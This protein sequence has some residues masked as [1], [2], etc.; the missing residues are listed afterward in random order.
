MGRPVM[1]GNGSLT[2]GLN[3]QGLVHDFYYP[4][5][6][7]DNLNTS[8]SMHHR[9]GVWVDGAFSW[10]DDG[11]WIID[12]DFE[13]TALVSSIRM[14]S[15]SLGIQ[16]D[17]V[18]FVDSELNAFCR[19]I[20]VNN[21][22]AEYRD[23]RLFMHQVFQ[24][25]RAGRAD[26][27]LFVPEDNYILDYK[28]RC[29]L[30]IYGQNVD[31]SL[32]D[33]FSVGNYGIEG[34][35]GTY[36]DAE[37]GEL[38]GNSVEHGGVDSV[39][40]FLCSLDS[41]GSQ[42]FDY[43]VVAADSQFTAE[44][45]HYKVKH[46]GLDHR[47]ELTREYW[48]NWLKTANATELGLENKYSEAI[49]KSLMVIK[50]HMD[51]RGG[52]IASCDSSIYNYGRD[53]YSYV[54]P[55]DGAYAI[56]PLI[57]LGY[58]NEPKLFFE[59]CRDILTPGGYLMHKYQPDR[60][61]GSTWHPLLH[62]RSKE[63]A[64]QEDETAIIIF[65]LGE[66]LKYSED[67][68]FVFSLYD[69]F[70]QPAANFICS[71][72]DE[73]TGLPHASYDLWEEKFATH[74]Y[75]AAVSY[76]AL[77]VAV[78]FAD[79]FEH[80]DD[81]ARWRQVANDIRS[82][83]GV[84]F[85]SERKAFRKS[86]LLQENGSLQFDN[87]LDISSLYGAVTFGLYNAN[88]PEVVQTIR[89]CNDI[90][91]DKSPSGGVPRYERDHY[92][93]SEPAYMGNPWFVTTLWLAGLDSSQDKVTNLRRQ[94]DWTMSHALPSGVLSEQVNSTDGSPLSVTPLVWSHAELI[95]SILELK[96]KPE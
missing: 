91:K 31:G 89:L 93:E 54:W 44:K 17:L 16:L 41:G 10:V 12:V 18:D 5:V 36:K 81:A 57:K 69:T 48:R 55:R 8:R 79:T 77:E 78:L 38:T 11:T 29:A 94:V 9:I 53:Y 43:W 71:F 73:H 23:V 7:L 45:L 40:R 19:R 15:H 62:G 66:Y 70:I 56:W 4:Y 33:Q 95:N 74:T 34:K 14:Q 35:E 26:T 83:R 13:S 65:M 84:F 75:T 20:V 50:A 30:L 51:R 46:D 3:E 58:R 64:I 85:D 22:T 42:Q 60:S 24:I 86:F 52:I 28:G 21:Q 32:Y 80:P 88:E 72:R 63:L 87:T 47:L 37:D 61:I 1:L 27:A 59:F 67:Q 2:V 82:N 92:F 76:K 90:L 96:S 39:I 6:G 68:D 49:R 25:S